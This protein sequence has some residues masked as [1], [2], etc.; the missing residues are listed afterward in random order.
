MTNNNL[1]S[2]P[3]HEEAPDVAALVKTQVYGMKNEL[4]EDIRDLMDHMMAR[5]DKGTQPS[6]QDV[7]SSPYLSGSTPPPPPS[8]SYTPPPWS[9]P[10]P[11]N[12]IHN[13]QPWPPNITQPSTS[14]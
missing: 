12:P 5:R 14:N 13:H 8:H 4:M 11:P 2:I 9:S 7:S 1:P 10:R 3:E 6:P